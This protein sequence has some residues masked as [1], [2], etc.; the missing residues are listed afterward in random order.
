M[1]G[2][3]AFLNNNKCETKWFKRRQENITTNVNF[4]CQLALQCPIQ[5]ISV[6][7]HR[8]IQHLTVTTVFAIVTDMAEYENS[9]RAA[10]FYS[11]RIKTVEYMKQQML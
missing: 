10:V 8:Y 7:P 9:S 5:T 1:K 2:I 11:A 4:G 6:K 3:I